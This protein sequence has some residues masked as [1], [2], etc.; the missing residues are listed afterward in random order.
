MSRLR[1]SLRIVVDDAAITDDLPV[2]VDHATP[3]FQTFSKGCWNLEGYECRRF[4]L[5]VYDHE[6]RRHHVVADKVNDSDNVQVGKKEI[7][8][9]SGETTLL[10]CV[11]E[12]SSLYA[13]SFVKLPAPTD[14]VDD[15]EVLQGYVEYLT[16]YVRERDLHD[17]MV[18]MKHA[19]DSDLHYRQRILCLLQDIRQTEQMRIMCLKEAESCHQKLIKATGGAVRD[20]CSKLALS[21]GQGKLSQKESL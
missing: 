8:F 4:E 7:S 14:C 20:A 5:V 2:M 1:F 10:S 18:Q 13:K 9:E 6:C 3:P 16:A 15:D 17:T 19:L 12:G 21:L 11:L